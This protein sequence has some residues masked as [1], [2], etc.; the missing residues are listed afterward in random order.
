LPGASGIV[1]QVN[2]DCC[3]LYAA[4]LAVFFVANCQQ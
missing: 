1:E 3:D 4:T 2:L